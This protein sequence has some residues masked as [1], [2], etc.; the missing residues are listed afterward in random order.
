MTKLIVNADKSQELNLSDL[1]ATGVGGIVLFETLAVELKALLLNASSTKTKV[2]NPLVQNPPLWGIATIEDFFKELNLRLHYTEDTSLY[3]TLHI[4]ASLRKGIG[5]SSK[6]EASF[7]FEQALKM[8]SFDLEVLAPESSLQKNLLF[9]DSEVLQ[10]FCKEIVKKVQAHKVPKTT[11]I[12]L[13]APAY[14]V[15]PVEFALNKAGWGCLLDGKLSISAVSSTYFRNI[16]K[17]RNNLPEKGKGINFFQ[18]MDKI[19]VEE[20]LFAAANEFSDRFVPV[21]TP[22]PLIPDLKLE[23]LKEVSIQAP[24][25]IEE[26]P[27]V[28]A[29]TSVTVEMESVV[30]APVQKPVLVEKQEQPRDTLDFPEIPQVPFGLEAAPVETPKPTHKEVSKPS[31]KADPT[32]KSKEKDKFKPKTYTSALPFGKILDFLK[33]LGLKLTPNE[34]KREIPVPVL[35]MANEIINDKQIEFIKINNFLKQRM[36]EIGAPT[37]D[38][39]DSLVVF[40]R[41]LS[42]KILDEEVIEGFGLDITTIKEVREMIYA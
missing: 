42:A 26:E 4:K 22:E 14:L 21:V 19:S 5:Y 11:L 17:I 6:A 41:A 31:Q 13:K 36:A 27:A 30:A 20:V 7:D 8:D 38:L 34:L 3:N 16:N 15:S 18:L 2:E 35:N 37:P 9:K 32:K 29:P 12:N 1:K 33:D 28:P 25:V 23:P 10:N 24:V 40:T 39:L